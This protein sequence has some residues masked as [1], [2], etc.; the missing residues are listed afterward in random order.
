M[1]KTVAKKGVGLRSAV[2]GAHNAEMNVLQDCFSF[3]IVGGSQG[4]IVLHITPCSYV[5][6]GSLEGIRPKYD[7]NTTSNV[8]NEFPLT[9]SEIIFVG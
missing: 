4:H 9:K 7:D 2:W 5:K 8:V 6:A 1:G 3:P